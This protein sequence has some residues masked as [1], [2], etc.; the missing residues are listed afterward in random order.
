MSQFKGRIKRQLEHGKLI[1]NHVLRR[2]KMEH[3][4]AEDDSETV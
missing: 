2:K 1:P 3:Q 4:V